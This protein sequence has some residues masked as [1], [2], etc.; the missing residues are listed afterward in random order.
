MVMGALCTTLLERTRRIRIGWSGNGQPTAGTVER[1]AAERVGRRGRGQAH[2]AEIERS[3][4][5]TASLGERL[6]TTRSARPL[7]SADLGCR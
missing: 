3:F 4:A 1:F 5:A 6:E 7:G 2:P